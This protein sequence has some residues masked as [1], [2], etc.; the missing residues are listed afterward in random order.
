MVDDRIM[1]QQNMTIAGGALGT[2]AVSIG[3]IDEFLEWMSSDRGVKKLPQELYKAVAWTYWCVNLRANNIAA[4]PYSIYTAESTEDVDEFAVD[5]PIDLTVPIWGASTWL[6]LVGAAYWLKLENDAGFAEAGLQVL[7]ANTMEVKFLTEGST[8]DLGNGYGVTSGSGAAEFGDPFVF[9][10]TVNGKKKVYRP[11]EIVYFRTFD[12]MDDVHEGTS[13]GEVGALSG[14]L[15][16][17]A[18]KWASAF[19]Q[20]N[21]MPLLVLEA[22]GQVDKGEI[23]RLKTAWNRSLQRALNW[24]VKIL[25]RGMK[26]NVIGQPVKDLAM[27]EMSKDQ[28]EQII[29]AHDLPIGFAEPKTNRAERQQL[30]YELYSSHLIPYTKTKILPV[31]N[32]L[33]LNPIG[34]RIAFHFNQ[35]EAI[36][37]EEIA[38]A[39]AMSFVVSDVVIP[40]F[41]AQLMTRIESRRVINSVLEGANL[42]SLDDDP[43]FQ[44][45]KDETT[46]DIIE[47]EIESIENELPSGVSLDEEIGGGELEKSALRKWQTKAIRR[48]KEG[49]P[50]KALRFESDHIAPKIKHLI[51]QSLKHAE[52]PGDVKAIFDAVLEDR[53]VDWLVSFGGASKAHVPVTIATTCPLCGHHKADVYEDHGGLSVCQGCGKTFDPE[54]EHA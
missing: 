26:V 37:R 12:P 54:V 29:A 41:A 23:E 9:V 50:E 24:S 20:N 44:D 47:G 53:V 13:S 6:D 36:Q 11:E 2:K 45:I 43:V 25:R 7:N 3:E 14:S 22:E 33:L 1:T 8:I 39:E 17:H 30:E 51:I 21:A 4:I 5:F 16:L 18:N 49:C 52:T 19:F 35:I 40:S 32:K 34:L 48:F 46:E 31:I 42:P 15:I 38:K 28:K 27:P 10:Q